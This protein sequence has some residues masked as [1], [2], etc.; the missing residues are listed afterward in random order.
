[1]SGEKFESVEEATVAFAKGKEAFLSLLDDLCNCGFYVSGLGH[2]RAVGLSETKNMTL[3]AKKSGS[4]SLSSESK[5][6]NKNF[7]G[8]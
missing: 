8:L 4:G 1:M 7:G 2:V 3:K 5:S 6:A